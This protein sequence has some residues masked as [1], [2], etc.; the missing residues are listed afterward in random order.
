MNDDDR[1]YNTVDQTQRET[2]NTKNLRNRDRLRRVE[3]RSLVQLAAY[4]DDDDSDGL[5]DLLGRERLV[6]GRTV[7]RQDGCAP[8]GTPPVF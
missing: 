7:H 8:C 1:E 6:G 2:F 4:P 5:Y 3:E